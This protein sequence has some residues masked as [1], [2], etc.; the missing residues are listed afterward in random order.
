[1]EIKADDSAPK[2][3]TSPSDSQDPE[4][5]LVNQNPSMPTE[6]H[7]QSQA[8]SPKTLAL[9]TSDPQ[10][11]ETTE[12]LQSQ[13]PQISLDDD[14][15]EPE[16]TSPPSAPIS[17]S[18]ITIIVPE[19]SG[20]QN[21]P[22]TTPSNARRSLKR[23]KS[24]QKKRRTALEKLQQ[25]K[26]VALGK[27]LNP[28]PFVPNKTLDFNKHEALLNRLGLWEFV[29]IEFDQTIRR[30]LLAQ[31]IANYTPSLR[32]SVVNGVKIK[33]NRADLARAMKLPVK[34][35]KASA[36][37]EGVL[38]APEAEEAIGFIDDLVSYWVLLHEDTWMMPPEVL[39]WRRV[40][41][42]GH[43]EKVDWAGLIWF[44]VEK[45]LHAEELVDCYYASH[46]QCVIRAQKEELLREEAR[47][48]VEVKEEED[49]GDVEMGE[50]GEADD[51]DVK[52][53][54]DVKLDEH[55]NVKLDE[56]VNVKLD[57]DVKM[58]EDF[59]MDEHVNV[60]EDVKMDE[61]VKVDEDAKVN[62]DL[63]TVGSDELQEHELEEHNIEL[64]LGQD[65]V[66]KE[67]VK[68]EDNI[69]FDECKEQEPGQWFLDG[70]ND[71][72]EPYLRHC[73][74]DDLKGSGCD[75]ERKQVEDED[76]DEGEGEEEEEQDRGFNLSPKCNNLA[77]LS[78][79]NLIHTIEAPQVTFNSSVQ[80]RDHSSMELLS[81]RAEANMIP[82]GPSIFSSSS[83]RDISHDNDISHQALS[84]NHKRIRSEFDMCME[85]ME[86]WM[87]K[88]KMIHQEKE[89]TCAE[90]SMNQ[91]ILIGELQQR[92]NL[93]ELLQKAKF[94]EFQKRE[95]ETYKRERELFVMANLLESYR[96]ALRETQRA[97]SEYRAHCPLPDE[98][99]YNDVGE[100]GGVVLSTMELEKQCRR[101]EEEYKMNCLLVEQKIKDFEVLWFSKL[102]MHLNVVHMLD[103]RLVDAE[104]NVKLLRESCAKRKVSETSEH[105]PK[106]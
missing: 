26:L 40:I 36:S 11:P 49:G 42:E 50:E 74:F 77:G 93:I 100:T 15:E 65:G 58:D 52:M 30:D 21:P 39:N 14:Q 12:L 16:G 44:M 59:K 7:P 1:M 67:K 79:E 64:S 71:D 45:E 4:E 5:A 96:K 101:Q 23:K 62:A 68:D 83:K 8:P 9:E 70:K 53:D 103:S 76:E 35:E 33:V 38:E 102:E 46:L 66:G 3:M 18:H 104:K 80:L 34:K 94:E 24:G 25:Q 54:E 90:A 85:Q 60:D 89:Q 95:V 61:Q 105:P 69:G 43:P 2:A 6:P 13:V 10:N 92:D 75:E 72:N 73:T 31:L 27:T 22:L 86:H 32:G 56:H 19:S 97:F 17:G 106:E 51:E 20:A 91:Q 81:S 47:D 41:K 48:E 28:I 29:H 78:S 82:G 99:L 37:L 98:P 63:G 55:V 84:S 57:E 88:A 87:G